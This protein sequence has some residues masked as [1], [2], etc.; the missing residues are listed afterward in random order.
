MAKQNGKSL[1]NKFIAAFWSNPELMIVFCCM[2]FAYLIPILFVP[3]ALI[4]YGLLSLGLPIKV[5]ILLAS[6]PALTGLR[7]H[8]Q[9]RD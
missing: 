7:I 3:W 5:S 1:L 2:S 6:L 8:M 4:T 9:W